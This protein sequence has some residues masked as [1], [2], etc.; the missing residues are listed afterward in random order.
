MG[1]A[2]NTG[3]LFPKAKENDK[4]QCAAL[5]QAFR[6]RAILAPVSCKS[7]V[8]GH[9]SCMVHRGRHNMTSG[10]LLPKM[11]NHN[12]TKK[13]L[14]ALPILFRNTKVVKN[15]KRLRQSHRLE[16]TKEI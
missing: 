15:K 9:P 8:T 11:L 16:G 14:C 5:S 12:L 7:P 10:V 3:S 6:A 13:T 1:I 4:R 2:A